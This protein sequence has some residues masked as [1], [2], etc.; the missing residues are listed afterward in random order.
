VENRGEKWK[1]LQEIID[2]LKGLKNQLF[3]KGVKLLGEG[4]RG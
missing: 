4:C 1:K 3:G 2:S